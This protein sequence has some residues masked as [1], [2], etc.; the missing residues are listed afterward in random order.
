VLGNIPTTPS[1]HDLRA[2]GFP[3]SILGCD[4]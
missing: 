3:P 2:S 4:F 1:I